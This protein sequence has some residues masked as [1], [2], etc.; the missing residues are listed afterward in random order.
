[1]LTFDH[2]Q[3]RF[4]Y[5]TVG[6]IYHDHHVLLHRADYESFWSLPGGRVEFA[7]S[8]QAALVRELREELGVAASIERL[9]WVVENF[10]E[11]SQQR[12]HEIAFYFLVSLPPNAAI[13]RQDTPFIGDE[14]GVVLIFQWFPV[15]QLETVDLYPS[16]LRQAL[17]RLPSGIE[18]IVHHDQ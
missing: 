4:N 10:Y 14:P 6:V 7:E 12:H 15:D 5:R 9:L 13:C 11:Y 8:A 3:G 18:H 1:M 16:F 2:V 17:Q